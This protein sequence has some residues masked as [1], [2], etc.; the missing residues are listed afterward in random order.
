MLEDEHQELARSLGFSKGFQTKE[1]SVLLP[2][3]LWLSRMYVM[4]CIQVHRGPMALRP[5]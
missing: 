3:L 5:P 4:R 2:F 1:L